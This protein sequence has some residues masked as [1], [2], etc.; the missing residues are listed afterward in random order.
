MI[1][2]IYFEKSA[3]ERFEIIKE[4]LKSYGDIFKISIDRDEVII[5]YTPYD[6]EFVYVPS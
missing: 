6:L 4:E 2:E 3:N 1:S 5:T